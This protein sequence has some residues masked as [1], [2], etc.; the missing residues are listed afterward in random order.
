ME[1]RRFSASLCSSWGRRYQKKGVSS[2]QSEATEALI[3]AAIEFLVPLRTFEGFD[4]GKFERLCE[5]L[6][7]CKKAWEDSEYVPKQ[8]AFIM[9]DLFPIPW[10]V[11]DHYANRDKGADPETIIVAAGTLN[12]LAQDCMADKSWEPG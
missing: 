9:L 12:S 6:K 3:G 8:A 1:I 10:A 4:Q 5:V 2:L 7:Q 11:A